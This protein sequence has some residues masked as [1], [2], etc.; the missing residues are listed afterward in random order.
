MLETQKQPESYSQSSYVYEIISD[1]SLPDIEALKNSSHYVNSTSANIQQQ[2]KY[3]N[4][5]TSD[6]SSSSSHKQTVDHLIGK[7]KQ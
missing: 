2:F 1:S 3:W 7:L 4:P 5:A 6:E